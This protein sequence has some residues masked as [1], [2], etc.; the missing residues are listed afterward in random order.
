MKKL[1]I[2]IFAGA[3][4]FFSSTIISNDSNKVKGFSDLKILHLGFHKGCLNDF[5]EVCGELGLNVTSW[6]ILS[7]DLP[8]EHFDGASTGNKVY[9]I[10][11]ERAKRV[12]EKH[13]DYFDQFDVIVTSDTAPLS[14]IFLQNGWKKPLIIWACNRFDYCDW[15]SRD[16]VFPDQEYYNLMN[17]ANNQENVKIIPYTDYEYIYAKRKNVNLGT[18][19]IKPI[20]AKEKEVGLDFKSRIPEYIKKNE[21]IFVYPRLP[22][23]VMRYV[24]NSCEKLGIKT[25]TGVYNGPEDLKGFKGIIYYP[26]AFS[27]LAT[28]ENFQR[29]LIHFVPS[30]KFIRSERAK[31]RPFR[32]CVSG[33]FKECEWYQ[34]QY[35]DV[36]VYFDSWQDLKDKIDIIDYESLSKK[37][38]AFGMNHRETMLQ[39][40][41]VVF[42]ETV[43]FLN[44][45]TTSPKDKNSVEKLERYKVF[46]QK[47][48]YQSQDF[49]HFEVKPKSRYE[50]FKQ[51]FENFENNDGK[52]V[53]EL[54]T[55]R[56]FLDGCYKGCLSPNPKYWEPDKPNMWDW[57]AG[58]F[59]IVSA[60][61]LAHLNPEFHSVDISRAAIGIAKAMTKKYADFMHFHTCS[62]VDFLRRWD[63]QKKIDLLYLDTGGMD[64]STCRLQLQEAKVIV[65][66]DLLAPGGMILID[67]VKNQTPRKL[68]GE[69]SNLGKSKYAIPY[70][71]EHGFKIV[72]DEY[73]VILM[74]E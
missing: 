23:N 27:N 11:H 8:R 35:K 73:Q 3:L 34:D 20:G 10:G 14:R 52:I 50:T 17:K 46:L 33:N 74:R 5:E 12:W 61:C 53:V 57:G 22:G 32:C 70:L 6:Y 48:T 29:G 39:K 41:D 65:E 58:S 24:K 26:Y 19:T 1:F 18:R 66:R 13:K 15:G 43:D 40:W 64:R 16:C 4:I 9:N 60:D 69:T 47:G 59:T 28:F 36:I 44:K 54:G 62:S 42:Q 49:S 7:A 25:F 38:K 21:T 63:T 37:I 45:K 51:A 30:E 2:S 68:Y 31:R 72:A 56:S 71:L 67:D 55:T